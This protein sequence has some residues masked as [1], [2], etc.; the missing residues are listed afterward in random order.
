MNIEYARMPFGS[1]GGGTEWMVNLPARYKH[2]ERGFDRRIMED[3]AAVGVPCYTLGDLAN[4]PA[5]IPQGIPIFIDWLANLD[6]R[7]P[8]PE[9]E[10]RSAIRS[11]L[12]RNLI[13]P[14][15]RGNQEAIDLLIAQVRREPPIPERMQTW[16]CEG[17]RLIAGPKHFDQLVAL[18]DELPAGTAIYALV[19]YLGKVKTPESR[20]VAVRYLDTIA[21]G[22]AI[23]ALVQM[24]ASGVRRLIEPFVQDRAPSVRKAAVRA[25]EK[26]P[27]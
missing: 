14:A 10:H 8:G 17:L 19:E 4:G 22:S 16:A 7:I 6:E 11:G 2:G 23:K 1:A 21:R 5:T 15:A 9:T 18:L 24:K 12:I 25:L 3:L 26:L 13:D 20:D 27:D